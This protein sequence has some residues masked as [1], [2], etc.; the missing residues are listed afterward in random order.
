MIY[1]LHVCK[2]WEYKLPHI[3]WRHHGKLCIV[4]QIMMAIWSY[5]SCDMCLD[6]SCLSHSNHAI[7]FVQDTNS[8]KI[9]KLQWLHFCHGGISVE[10]YHMIQ[11]KNIQ[12]IMRVVV[13]VVLY[14]AFEIIWQYNITLTTIASHV[15]PSIFRLLLASMRTTIRVAL[16]CVLL[17]RPQMWKDSALF[18]TLVSSTQCSFH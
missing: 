5:L 16:S 10:S 9:S 3:K 11:Y 13:V 7:Q 8:Y 6:I 18:R 17:S 1:I 4:L 14:F 15:P 12:Y 2:L